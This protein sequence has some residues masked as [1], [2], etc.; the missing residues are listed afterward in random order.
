MDR[1]LIPL[2]LGCFLGT[3]LEWYDYALYS[4]LATSI[5]V[6]F[7]PKGDASIAL[8]ETFAVFALSFLV[9]PLGGVFWGFIGDRFGRKVSL[10]ASILLISGSTACIGLIPAYHAIGIYAPCLLL[11]FRLLQGLSA[12]G[13][14][15][16]A[17]IILAETV[18]ARLR[19]VLTAVV[20]AGEAMGLLAGACLIYGFSI[21]SH[22]GPMQDWMW[23]APFLVSI[24]LG[25]LAFF[26]RRRVFDA[27]PPSTFTHDITP[28]RHLVGQYR[29]TLL[30]GFLAAVLDAV[31]FYF[32]LTFLPTFLLSSGLIAGRNTVK[33]EILPLLVFVPAV[34]GA[35]F[36]ADRLGARKVLAISALCFMLFYLPILWLMPHLPPGG[37]L[38][39]ELLLAAF[40]ALADGA[41]PFF[42]AGLFPAQ[43]RYSGFAVAF[44]LS[45][46]VFGGTTPL[47]MTLFTHLKYAYF[48]SASWIIGAAWLT[49]LAVCMAKDTKKVALTARD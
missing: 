18:P 32:V 36:L 38:A 47:V 49:L 7:F 24:P 6:T 16:G 17:A 35:G 26:L 33:W 23:R 30:I 1:R 4:Y 34:M 3:F 9:R 40:L 29:G 48:L 21:L 41:L 10:S 43:V 8:M 12:A 31:G 19:G 46:T 2:V 13:E 5:S 27:T 14:Y 15:A 11:F 42:L 22:G 25:L 39:C 28:I 44:N 45:N 37:I 20:P